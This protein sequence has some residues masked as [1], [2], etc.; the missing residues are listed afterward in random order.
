MLVPAFSSAVTFLV[1]QPVQLPVEPKAR[2][3]ATSWPL[4]VMSSG[5][6]A[7]VPLANLRASVVLVGLRRSPP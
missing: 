6:F 4:T 5:R 2:S 1:C 7:V 3:S